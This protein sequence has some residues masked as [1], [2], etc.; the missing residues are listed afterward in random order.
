[1]GCRCQYRHVVDWCGCS[2]NDFKPA[3]WA[4]LQ[5]NIN[6]AKLGQLKLIINFRPPTNGKF[7]LPGNLSPLSTKQSS[8]NLKNGYLN[9]NQ[10]TLL[11]LIAT[12]KVF[13]INMTRAPKM[14]TL[15]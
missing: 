11:A 1:M 12:G 14:M 2:P 5:V 10:T 15:S 9:Q 6:T 3:D 8:S 13:T 4:R 7:S